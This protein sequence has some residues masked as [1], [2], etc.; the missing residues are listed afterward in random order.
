MRRPLGFSV[1]IT[2]QLVGLITRRSCSESYA[3]VAQ[4]VEQLIRNQQVAGSSPASSSSV[5]A[6]FVSFATTFL[7]EK[8]SAHSRRCSSSPQKVTLGSLSLPTFCGFALCSAEDSFC[9]TLT[10][11]KRQA[12]AC[13]FFIRA[14]CLPKANNV[15]GGGVIRFAL[16]LPCD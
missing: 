8:L 13:L 6:D 9:L 4:L 16:S 12:K 2:G 11:K 14:R 3:T 5:V 1:G 7:L 15:R 10:M